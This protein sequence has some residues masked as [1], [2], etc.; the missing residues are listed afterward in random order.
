MLPL[1]RAGTNSDPA[2][3]KGIGTDTA[4]TAEMCGDQI[5]GPLFESW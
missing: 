3:G 5:H 4:I 1:P 2:S